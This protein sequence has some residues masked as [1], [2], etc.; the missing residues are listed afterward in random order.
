M[1][2]TSVSFNRSSRLASGGVRYWFF[3][4][5]AFI[6]SMVWMLHER[7]PH[8]AAIAMA[9]LVV[10]LMESFRTGDIPGLWTLISNYAQAFSELPAGSDSDSTESCRLDHG[11]DEA[12]SVLLGCNDAT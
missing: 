3:P 2:T 11:V 10:M 5:L 9:L 12:L 8:R 7:N 1:R 6:A 4:L